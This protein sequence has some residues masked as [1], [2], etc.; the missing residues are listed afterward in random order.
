M[1]DA[2]AIASLERFSYWYPGTERPAVDDVTLTLDHDAVILAG[3]SGSGKTTVLRTLNGLVPHFHGGR[4]RGHVTVLG[5]DALRTPT[6]TLARAVGMVFQEPETQLVLARVA[7]DVAFGLE[8]QAVPA[9]MIRERVAGALHALAIGHLR[10]RRVATLSGGER[11]RVALAGVLALAPRAI[12]LDE[13]SSQLD[14][15]GA[16]AL[17]DALAGCLDRGIALVLAEHHPERMRMRGAVTLQL[18]NGR[19]TAPTPP[20][21]RGHR[22]CRQPPADHGEVLWST[23]GLTVGHRDPV[24]ETGRLHGV[25]GE[26]LACTGP[27]G[28][29]KTTLLRTLAG[30]LSPLTGSVERRPVRAAYLPQ[31]PG[32]LLHLP[33]LRAELL[34]TQRW[35]GRSAPLRPLLDELGLGGLGDR[36]PRDCSVGERQRAALAAVL[37]GEPELILLD[38]PTRGMDAWARGALGRVIDRLA[39]G[40]AA[41]VV[42]TSDAELADELAD[43]LLVVRSGRLEAGRPA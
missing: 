17:A 8:N 39:T 42:A 28:S 32:A 11:Q 24:L 26:V 16:R 12:V 3:D 10:D 19:L 41:I 22:R 40:G 25:R 27:N 23:D 18:A 9:P 30:F 2:G 4:A 13:P 31:D 7:A 36:D 38:E 1:T 35:L 5:R 15:A 14:P 37:A 21:R 43:R 6:R 33:T 29:G 34:Q 20:P